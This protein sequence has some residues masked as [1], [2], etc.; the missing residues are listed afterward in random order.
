[1]DMSGCETL[2][3]LG[4]GPGTYAFHLGMHNPELKLYLLDLPE[5]LEIAREVEARYPLRGRV[6]Y[7]PVDVTKDEIPGTYD[8][9][10]ISNTLHMLGE[11]ESRKLLGRLYPIVKPGGSL[12]VQFQ[13]M[14]EDRRGRRWPVILDLIQLCVTENGRNHTVAETREWMRDSGYVDIEFS[15][16][17]LLNTNG[18]VRGYRRRAD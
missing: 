11:T 2:L 6:T 7:L 1:L 13:Y 9:V 3:D 16:M 14:N 4:C 15:K 12:V 5:V 17:S 10:L 18:Y 8:I